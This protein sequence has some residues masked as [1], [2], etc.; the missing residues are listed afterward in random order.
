MG[1]IIISE[2]VDTLI[3]LLKDVINYFFPPHLC[4]S[5]TIN[6]NVKIGWV[7]FWK[8]LS[9]CVSSMVFVNKTQEP[10]THCLCMFSCCKLTPSVKTINNRVKLRWSHCCKNKYFFDC[11]DPKKYVTSGPYSLAI[12]SFHPLNDTYNN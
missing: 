11:K 7:I 9:S 2:Y 1:Y 6:Q 10:D 8:N 5:D 12:P 3:S 4:H